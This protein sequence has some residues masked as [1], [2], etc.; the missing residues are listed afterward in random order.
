[1][2]ASLAENMKNLCRFW[3]DKKVYFSLG[4]RPVIFYMD[5]SAGEASNCAWKSPH[6]SCG[7]D[8]FCL[9]KRKFVWVCKQN[10]L[11]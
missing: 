8:T 4:N 11:L 5:I 9:W 7:N 1:M 3:L 6:A 2:S 10:V